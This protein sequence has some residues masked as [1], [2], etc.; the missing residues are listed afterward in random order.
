MQRQ[1]GSRRRALRIHRLRVHVDPARGN[2]LGEGRL[3]SVG[4]DLGRPFEQPDISLVRGRRRILER[5]NAWLVPRKG[6]LGRDSIKC[7]WGGRV[8]GLPAHVGAGSAGSKPKP[9]R[10]PG[11]D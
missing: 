8:F 11:E 1:R 5:R 2:L 4:R 6:Y 3:Q 9:N 7:L 10:S